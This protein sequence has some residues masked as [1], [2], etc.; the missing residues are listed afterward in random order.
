MIAGL[1]DMPKLLEHVEKREQEQEGGYS[2]CV[3]I[4]E[5]VEDGEKRGEKQGLEKVNRLNAMLLQG[6]R[7]EDLKR[8]VADAAFQ[9][10]LF[11]EFGL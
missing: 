6:G 1:A 10:K 5:M 7:I 11:R 8:A 2:M 9:K 4:D 3:A